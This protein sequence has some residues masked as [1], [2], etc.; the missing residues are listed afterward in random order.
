MQV[1]KVQKE[2]V[3]NVDHAII[4]HKEKGDNNFISCDRVQT[5]HIVN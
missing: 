2:F 3:H 4:L 1:T 5:Q